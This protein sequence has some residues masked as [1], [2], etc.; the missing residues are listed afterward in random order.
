MI[1][2]PFDEVLK[3]F[4]VKEDIEFIYQGDLFT[5]NMGMSA[6]QNLIEGDSYF[7][8]HYHTGMAAG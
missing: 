3:H 7:M 4:P 1:Y 5:E 6:R 2:I 8:E